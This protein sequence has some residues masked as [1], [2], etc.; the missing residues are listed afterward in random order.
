MKYGPIA[1]MHRA[2]EELASIRT[3]N[4][5]V[6]PLVIHVRS[7]RSDCRCSNGLILSRLKGTND[8]IVP[9]NNSLKI[10]KLVPQAELVTVEGAGHHLISEEAHWPTVASNIVKFLSS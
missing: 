7:T 10:K 5:P 1:G 8:A 2:Y 4:G 6:K 3:A 9:Y